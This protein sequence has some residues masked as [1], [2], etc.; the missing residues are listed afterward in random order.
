[1][2]RARLSLSSIAV[3]YSRRRLGR[4]AFHFRLLFHAFS[5]FRQHNVYKY[6]LP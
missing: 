1:M 2:L 3:L 4:T 5:R 6:S